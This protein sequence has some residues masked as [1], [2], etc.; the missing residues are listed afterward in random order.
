MPEAVCTVCGQ[1]YAPARRSQKYCSLRCRNRRPRTSP[2]SQ[3]ACAQCGKP[4]LKRQREAGRYPVSFCS[5]SCATTYRM[6]RSQPVRR[7]RY[8]LPLTTWTPRGC[9]T[10]SKPML[11]GTYCSDYCQQLW[12]RNGVAC[13]DP[14]VCN[15]CGATWHR[16][17][18]PGR[19]RYCSDRCASKPGKRAWKRARRAR[20]KGARV[21]TVDL[22][23]VAQRDGWRC[24]ICK[25]KVTRATWSLDHLVPLAHG[26]DHSYA[27]TA[28]A[29]HRCNAIRSDTGP[30][31]LL[32]IG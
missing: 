24:H 23:V 17:E 15:E 21:E 16:W 3:V 26:G 7:R 14:L 31:Q 12:A 8:R 19:T 2:T 10:C 6:L 1:N 13:R 20:L 30:A 32:L 25:R 29:H 4:T 28:L 27:N 11:D 9:R 22:L 18:R 5:K